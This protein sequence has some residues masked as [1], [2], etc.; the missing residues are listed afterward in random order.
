VTPAVYAALRAS[1]GERRVAAKLLGCA[2]GTL[3]LREG[4]WS[5]ITEAAGSV[6]Q[7]A[8]EEM[9]YAE[10][11]KRAARRKRRLRTVYGGALTPG[12]LRGCFR[13][14]GWRRQGD[15]A[16][17]LLGDEEDVGQVSRWVRGKTRV[18][19]WVARD[20]RVLLGLVEGEAWPTGRVAAELVLPDWGS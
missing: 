3:R 19:E 8:V 16:R 6:L 1:L 7:G 9:A 5:R 11:S 17:V 14:L 13:A 10:D 15:A 12:E 4:G 20:L 2:E 18:P